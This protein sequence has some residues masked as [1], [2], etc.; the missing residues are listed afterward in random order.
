MF[1]TVRP[2]PRSTRTDS[3][4][5]YTTLFGSHCVPAFAGMTTLVFPLTTPKP[6]CLP[7]HAFRRLRPRIAV[8]LREYHA[9]QRQRLAEGLGG[10]GRDRK[11]TP[12]NSSH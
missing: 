5:S 7:Q 10:V 9:G 11:S 2:P 12:L 1:F 3:L 8:G 4:F 6:I